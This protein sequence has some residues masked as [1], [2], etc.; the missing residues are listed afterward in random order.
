MEY[1][2]TR[3]I[4]SRTYFYPLHRQPAFA[5]LKTGIDDRDFP[6]SIL[7]YEQ[8]VCLPMFP[9]LTDEQLAHVCCCIRDFFASRN[10]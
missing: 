4:E 3:G 7:G 6:N 9:T 2:K 10:V 8:G 5:Y 1:M